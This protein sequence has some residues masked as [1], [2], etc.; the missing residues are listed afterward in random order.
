[1]VSCSFSSQCS[2]DGAGTGQSCAAREPACG[3][4][5]FFEIFELDEGGRRVGRCRLGVVP[6]FFA[7]TLAACPQLKVRRQAPRDADPGGQETQRAADPG[8]VTAASPPPAP[9]TTVQADAVAALAAQVARRELSRDWQIGRRA[10]QP[11]FAG[12]TVVRRATGLEERGFAIEQLFR[13]L[14]H[15]KGALARLEEAL[16]GRQGLTPDERNAFA[17]HL[18]GIEG[19]FTTFNLL[20]KDRNDGFQGTGQKP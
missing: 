4:C 20:F 2:V 15:V 18:R 8:Q 9:A 10:M 14:C 16:D 3:Q 5:A 6:R 1:M 12:G 13:R 19:S 7:C 11:R 17:R